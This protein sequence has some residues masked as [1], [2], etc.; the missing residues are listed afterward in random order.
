MTCRPIGRLKNLLHNLGGYPDRTIQA[1]HLRALARQLCD[2]R[3][4][5]HDTL[6]AVDAVADNLL[7]CQQQTREEFDQVFDAFLKD[8]HQQTLRSLLDPDLGE[9]EAS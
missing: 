5:G 4:T 1:A 8:G 7:A 3:A 2:E 9:G 6:R